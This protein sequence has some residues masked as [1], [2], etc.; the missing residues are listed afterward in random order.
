MNYEF[1]NKLKM[2]REKNKISQIEISKVLNVSRATYSNYENGITEPS[3]NTII[4]ISKFYNVSIDSLLTGVDNISSD[5]INTS[6]TDINFEIPSFNKD[7]VLKSL[8]NKKNKYLKLLESNTTLINQYISEIDSLI[9]AIQRNINDNDVSK[10]PSQSF[11]CKDYDLNK[12]EIIDIKNSKDNKIKENKINL[13]RIFKFIDATGIAGYIEP[14][15]RN[16]RENQFLDLT[17]IDFNETDY[18]EIPIISEISAGLPC[19]AYQDIDYNYSLKIPDDYINSNYDYFVLR[20]K[21]DSMNEIYKD[22]ELLLIRACSSV[23]NGEIAV[24][25]I[26]KDTATLKEYYFD[27]ETRTVNLIPHSSFEDYQN[28]PYNVDEHNVQVLGKVEKILKI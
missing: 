28:Q 10:S 27:R 26:D 13:D 25:S 12:S 22:K 5:F 3:I 1:C 19:L 18:T 2:L 11:D 4:N 16:M 17:N 7:S 23:E 24:V 8:F 15:L 6:D 9:K 20:V 21:G 14:K